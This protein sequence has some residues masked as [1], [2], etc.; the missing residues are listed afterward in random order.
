M[1]ILSHHFAIHT[2]QVIYS[3]FKLLKI[4]CYNTCNFKFKKIKQA[5]NLIIIINYKAWNFIMKNNHYLCNWL[6]FLILIFST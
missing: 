4:F 6:D 5:K 3:I 2:L 1:Y